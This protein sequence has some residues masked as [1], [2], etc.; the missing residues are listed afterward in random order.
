M[1]GQTGKPQLEKLDLRRR[2]KHLYSPSPKQVQMVDVPEL[3]YL[4]IEG[5]LEAGVRPGDSPSFAEDMGEMYGVSYALKFMS[6]LD[7]ENPIDYKVTALEG[8]WSSESGV[9]EWGKVEPWLY[10]L[11]MLQP[12]HISREMFDGAVAKT[13]A[14]RPSPALDRLQLERWMEGP[15]I[16]IMHIGPYD[17][18]PR[19]LALMEAYASEQGLEMHG[20]HHE[21]YLGDPRTANPAKLR[22]ILRHPVKART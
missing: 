15:S 12:D 16:Q 6:K 5:R 22:T 18:E 20:R 4:S 1:A 3:S 2:Y 17:D 21:I 19:T 14:K 8:L 10:R 13:R 9:F 7:P 11:L